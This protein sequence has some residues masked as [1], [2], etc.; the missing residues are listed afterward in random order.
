MSEPTPAPDGAPVTPD[1][2]S[3]QQ[4]DGTPKP[5]GVGQDLGYYKAEAKKAFD[6]RDEA[7]AAAKALAAQNKEIQKQ[8][9]DLKAGMPN[10]TQ[11]QLEKLAQIEAAEAEASRTKA[12]EAGDADAIAA[13][14][15]KPLEEQVSQ[16]EQAKAA[17]EAQLAMLLR[18]Q[19]LEQAV[20]SSELKPVD[21]SVVVDAL[22]G[23]VS[24][25]DVGGQFVAEFIGTDGQPLYNQHGKVTD[26][27]VFVNDYLS[28]HPGLC[29][30]AAKPGS[31]APAPGPHSDTPPTAGRKPTSVAEWNTWT[32]EQKDAAK[33]SPQE[34]AAMA[35]P[36]KKGQGMFDG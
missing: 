23:R 22:R 18:D 5:D 1:P 34:L 33:M 15:R 4:G 27:T 25:R 9:D 8:I 21:A 32:P 10:V 29:K 31:G 7:K 16:L 11:A 13:S 35:F 36:E 12:L 26:P 2:S 20:R 17:R 3:Q 30:A 6:A 28:A 24:M 14:A 19:A